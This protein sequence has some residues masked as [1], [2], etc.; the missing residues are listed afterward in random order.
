MFRLTR[1]G[2]KLEGQSVW[3]PQPNK[4][5]LSKF[6]SPVFCNGNLYTS[7]QEDKVGL[8]CVEFATGKEKWS[9]GNLANAT[10]ILADDHLLVFTEKGELQIARVSPDK[11]DGNCESRFARR[12]LLDHPDVVQRPSV[13]AQF[14]GRGVLRPAVESSRALTGPLLTHRTAARA[15]LC[16]SALCAFFARCRTLLAPA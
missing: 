9:E 11:Y 6:Q 8:N 16:R 15:R 13:R 4:V 10:I 12:A 5:I 2:D 7:S 3:D 14:Q 1:N